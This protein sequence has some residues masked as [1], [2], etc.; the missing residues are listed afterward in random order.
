M[1]AEYCC[2]NQYDMTDCGA[3]CLA[4]IAK[5]NLFWYN[6]GDIYSFSG[7]INKLIYLL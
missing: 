1:V 3:A 5:Q 6:D 7:N 2:I 4:T